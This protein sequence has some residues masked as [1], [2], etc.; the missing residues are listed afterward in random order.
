MKKNIKYNK[1]YYEDGVRSGISGY[2]DYRWIPTRSIPEAL[3]IKNNFVFKTC[4][5]FGCAKG[6]LVHALRI[7]GC[8]ARGEDISQYAIENC[9]P[10]VK[11]FLNVTS[12]ETTKSGPEGSE[13]YDLVISKDV[14]EHIREEEI[15]EVLEYLR[16]KGK[17]FFFVIPLGD[18]N[19]FRIREYEIDI[20]HVTKKDEEWW[21]EMFNKCG[22][23]LEK[24][25][26][27]FGAIKE[28][29]IKEFK[30]GNGFFILKK[31]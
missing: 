13:E 28:K 22:F 14:L 2:E 9:V 12:S 11:K 25:S 3:E 16:C 20:T 4:L 24:F 31:K 10:K 21:I 8:D 19:K 18:D 27:S 5:D 17:K 23:E 15:P 6:F 26:Y 7:L 30:F 29:W 1:E